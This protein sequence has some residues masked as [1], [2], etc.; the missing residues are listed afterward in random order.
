LKTAAAKDA[1]IAAVVRAADA[2]DAKSLVEV[3]SQLPADALSPSQKLR[4]LSSALGKWSEVDPAAAAKFLD[5]YPT[6]AREFYGARMTIAQNWAAS[7]P[8]AALAWAGAQ[9]D[10]R[11]AR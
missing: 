1:A 3:V 7:D 4:S 8:I 10:G 2:I 9:G 5:Q 11:E 6:Q